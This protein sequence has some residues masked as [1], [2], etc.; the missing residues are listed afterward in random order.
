MVSRRLVAVGV[1]SMDSVRALDRTVCGAHAHAHASVPAC[2]PRH[3]ATRGP[4]HEPCHKCHDTHKPPL[5]I[6]PQR[7]RADPLCTAGKSPARNI[8]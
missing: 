4:P 2:M 6:T 1:C 8:P 5:V 3:C 7:V